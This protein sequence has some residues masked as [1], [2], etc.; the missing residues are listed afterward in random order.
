MLFARSAIHPEFLSDAATRQI[1]YRA[2]RL[3]QR[4]YL[5]IEDRQD[6]CQ[7]F[8][9]SLL[10][11][12]K[13]FNP[14]RTSARLFITMVL[15]RRYKEY[16]RKFIRNA[17]HAYTMPISIDGA[18][19]QLNDP[20]ANNGIRE[21]C[22]SMDLRAVIAALPS[23]DRQICLAVMQCSSPNKAARSLGISPSS[24]YRTLYRLRAIFVENNI[25]PNS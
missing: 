4:F 17:R 23:N 5:S 10:R 22:G 24:V 16:V 25:I 9:F 13:R 7:D 21:L 11:A 1:N 12:E 19:L 15:N 8:W 6:L 20:D 3:K 18:N 14:E 2:N